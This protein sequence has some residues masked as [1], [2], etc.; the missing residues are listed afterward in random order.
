VQRKRLTIVLAAVALL[1]ASAASIASAELTERGDLFVS[2]KGG[3]A[4]NA[5][6]RTKLA[7]IAVSVA[8]TV[9]TLSGQRPPALRVIKIE[10]N[11]GGVLDSRGLPVCHYRDLVATSPQ[12]V[13]EACGDAQV[14]SGAYRAKTAFPEQETF[15]SEG[16]I[17]AFNGFYKGHSAILA[18]IY[19]GNPV[20]ITR[21]V[22]FRIHRTGGTFGTIL[23]GR[24]SDT[25]NHYGRRR[26]HLPE[27]VPA[28]RLPR[29]TTQLHQRC[30]RGPG[31]VRGRNLPLRARFDDLCRRPQTLEHPDAQLQCE[32]LARAARTFGTQS[33]FRERRLSWSRGR[34]QRG[35]DAALATRPSRAV[36]GVGCP[37]PTRTLDL[38]NGRSL[39]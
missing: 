23:T 33:A 3:I 15:P 27:A 9:K 11:R 16:Q 18:H 31:G 29:R 4:P 21:I 14:G 34:R 22:V 35:T 38:S 5:L 17:L 7:P 1:M 39:R 32:R 26:R 12:Q 25:V 19:G 20:P 30:L 37:Q 10:L 13:M 8:G 24:L 36:A 28:L 2:F 6:P